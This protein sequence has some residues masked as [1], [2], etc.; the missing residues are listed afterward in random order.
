MEEGIRAADGGREG[1]RGLQQG[2][3]ASAGQTPLL[4]L[5]TPSSPAWGGRCTRRREPTPCYFL[6]ER[7]GLIPPTPSDLWGSHLENN[8][9]P[10]EKYPCG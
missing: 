6:E 1:G 3:M 4:S 7:H 9:F 8:R 2:V 10:L 5:S